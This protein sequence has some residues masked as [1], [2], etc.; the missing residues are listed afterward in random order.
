MIEK[1]IQSL[2]LSQPAYNFV[3]DVWSLAQVFDD[4]TD[5]DEVKKDDLKRSIYAAFV[6]LPTNSFYMQH[7]RELSSALFVA[8]EKWMLANKVE[9]EGKHDARSY[10]WRAG[11]YDVVALVCILDNSDPHAALCLY[12][13]KYEDYMKEME[14]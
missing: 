5:G 3:M 6:T 10:M 14:V 9:D 1:A 12:G 2:N 7:S 11:F 8:I 4:V 13:E